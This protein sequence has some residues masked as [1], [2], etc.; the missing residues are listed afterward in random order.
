MG[1]AAPATFDPI[2]L[3]ALRVALTALRAG[4]A[5]DDAVDRSGSTGV[6]VSSGWDITSQCVALGPIQATITTL[7]AVASERTASSAAPYSSSP[8]RWVIIPSVRIRPLR[9]N[10]IAA[11]NE[12]ISANEPTMLI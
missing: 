5:I 3:T 8:K 9:R 6:V 10:P 7:C 1:S 4:L 2:A 12:V 11:S